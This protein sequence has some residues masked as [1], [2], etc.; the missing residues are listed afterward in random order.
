MDGAGA[1]LSSFFL[2]T[3]VCGNVAGLCS[4][5]IAM[6]D[7]YFVNRVVLP[8]INSQKRME[9]KHDKAMTELDEANQM[10][11]AKNAEVREKSAELAV[12]MIWVVVALDERW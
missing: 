1:S 7:F 11:E 5:T 6:K 10:L 9:A 8:L 3:Q 4:W 2:V 12:V